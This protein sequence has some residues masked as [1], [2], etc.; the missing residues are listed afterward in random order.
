M[1]HRMLDEVVLKKGK[2]SGMGKLRYDA[3]GQVVRVE[4]REDGK[5]IYCIKY[6][7]DR[8]EERITWIAE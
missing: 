6:V 2:Q 7:D 3:R 5:E 8:L 1:K 4:T